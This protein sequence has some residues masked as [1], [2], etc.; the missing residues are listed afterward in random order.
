VQEIP[1]SLKKVLQ[2]KAPDIAMVKGDIL[3]VPGSPGKAL[4]YRGAEAAFSMTSALAVI[5][6]RP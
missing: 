6:I 4:A 2:A 1:V 5:A 3:F